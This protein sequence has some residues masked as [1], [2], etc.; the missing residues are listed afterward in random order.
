MFVTSPHKSILRLRKIR[1]LSGKHSMFETNKLNR[2]TH[3]IVGAI[4]D[5]RE[6]KNAQ[7]SL[8]TLQNQASLL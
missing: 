2:D 5:L 4:L 8:P 7:G 1:L 6:Q 3:T